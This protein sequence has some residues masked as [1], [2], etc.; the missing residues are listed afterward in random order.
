MDER[1]RRGLFSFGP[2]RS[3]GRSKIGTSV[4]WSLALSVTRM[5]IEESS[6]Y[7]R[8]LYTAV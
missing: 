4:T 8:S 2:S 5:V 6:I 3:D 7:Y 1:E